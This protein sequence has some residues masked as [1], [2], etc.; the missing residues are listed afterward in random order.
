MYFLNMGHFLTLQVLPTPKKMGL[1]LALSAPKLF[2][3]S[4]N[5]PKC[6]M[7]WYKKKSGIWILNTAYFIAFRYVLS[8]KTNGDSQLTT[9]TT[10]K[11]S[12]RNK[13]KEHINC[14]ILDTGHMF[15][16][17]VPIYLCIRC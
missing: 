7:Q 15:L 8:Y 3:P 16:I 10:T 5:I 6:Q 4:T 1:K 17:R 13:P 11:C 14:Y 12:W 9:T 2:I